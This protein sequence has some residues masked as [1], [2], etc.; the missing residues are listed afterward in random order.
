[1]SK[2]G[3]RYIVKALQFSSTK[4]WEEDALRIAH[5]LPR[6]GCVVDLGCNTG[7]FIKGARRLRPLLK[8]IGVDVN[9]EALRIARKQAPHMPPDTFV[10]SLSAVTDVDV[11]VCIHALIQM[12]N[13]EEVLAEVWRCLKPEGRV[14]FLLHNSMNRWVWKIPNMFNG[15]KDDE[16]I[17]RRY[18]KRE[19]VALFRTVGFVCDSVVFSNPEPVWLGRFSIFN[20]YLT[21]VGRKQ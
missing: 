9:T 4:V 1:M 10:S 5:T 19:V 17:S 14:V 20:Q 16:T 8:F 7:K 3:R 18:S 6:R 15:Y 13:P 2:W 11:V 21:Y 12:E